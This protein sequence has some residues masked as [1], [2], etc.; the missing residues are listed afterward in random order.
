[1]V[2]VE[3][4]EG[5]GSAL[6]QKAAAAPGYPCRSQRAPCQNGA[7]T[8]RGQRKA[9]PQ[10]R[11]SIT[12]LRT[13]CDHTEGRVINV[14]PVELESCA[15]PASDVVANR[16]ALLDGVALVL[17]EMMRGSC[18]KA[19]VGEDVM[20]FHSNVPP[21][22]SMAFYLARIHRLIPLSDASF[23]LPL[24]YIS[25]LQQVFPEVLQ[26]TS[27]VRLLL[28][29]IM[30][31]SKFLDDEGDVHFNSAAYA[32]V[33]GLTVQE[34]DKLEALFCRHLDW[35]FFATEEEYA[36]FHHKVHSFTRLGM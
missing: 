2:I 26:E 4:T 21:K 1:M 27:W 7:R 28:T 33:G 24:V 34:L 8:R 5:L 16:Q 9:N 20:V 32:K 14:P 25:R 11:P 12:E 3:S 10:R 15:R 35:K 23:I 31:S 18:G 30:L 36:G 22:I 29:G 19:E 13:T 17:V 6:C